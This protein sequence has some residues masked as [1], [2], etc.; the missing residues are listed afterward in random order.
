MY[1]CNTLKIKFTQSGFTLVE[2]LVTIFIVGALIA[3]LSATISLTSLI[4]DSKYSDIAL[5]IATHKLE[6]ERARGYASTTPGAFSDSLLSLLPGGTATS[7]VTNFNAKT[8][9]VT[10]TVT[11]IGAGSSTRSQSLNTLITEVGGL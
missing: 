11:W 8:K 6:N 2:V 7:S 5:R 1:N 3:L 4:R 10:V 9:H